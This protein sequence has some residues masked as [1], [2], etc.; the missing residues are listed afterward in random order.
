MSKQ[1]KKRLVPALR[2]P[3][4]RDKGE[5]SREKLGTVATLYKGKGISKAEI[6]ANGIRPCIHYGELYTIYGETIHETVSRTNVDARELFL[7]KSNDVIIPASGETKIDIAKASCV[8]SDD[9]A[10]GGDLNVI[11]SSLNGIFLSYQLNGPLRLSIAKVAQGD[12][13]VHLY[14]TQIERLDVLV[15]SRTEQQ[16]IADCLT[17]IDE[18][19]TAHAQKLDALKAHKKGL[20]Q[21]LFPAEGETEPKLRFH[22]FRDKGEWEKCPLEKLTPYNKKYG[23][24]DGP[25]GSNLKTIHYRKEGV[26]IITSGYVTEGFFVAEKYDYVTPEKFEQEKRSAVKGGDIVMAKIGARCGASAIM[27]I[28]HPDGILS[29]NALK[30]TVDET[31]FSTPFVWQRLWC[32]YLSQGLDG[33]KKVGAQPAISIANLKQFE[34]TLPGTRD[35]QQR[36]ADCLTSVDELITSQT[37]KLDA[38]KAHKK[39]L[40]QQLFPAMDEVRA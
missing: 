3:D 39:G 34:I 9:I 8:M 5:W 14:P 35:E 28:D 36:I 15:P 20:M 22:E 4:F 32:L 27:P 31:R 12:T 23:I 40:M 29:G 13:V 17:S 26:P 16:K 10:L 18:L 7:S 19:V 11:R 30:I 21:Q 1:E 24:V 6:V 33:L 38:L 25:F 2:F 37:K